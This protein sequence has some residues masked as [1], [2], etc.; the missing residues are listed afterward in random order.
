MPIS[1]YNAA[2]SNFTSGIMLSSDISPCVGDVCE[3]LLDVS[4]YC[5]SIGSI[6]IAVSATNE[7]GIG[8]PS[9]PISISKSSCSVLHM[10]CVAG[11][12]KIAIS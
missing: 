7:L 11:S 2:F 3:Y 10:C 1:S 12:R 9:D 6:S 4:T 8:L 5:R